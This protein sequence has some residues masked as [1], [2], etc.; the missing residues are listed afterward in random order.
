LSLPRIQHPLFSVE[1]PSSKK[2]IKFRPFTARE[3]K[4]LLIAKQSEDESDIMGAIKQVVRNCVVSEGFDVDKLTIFDLEYLFLQIRIKSVSDIVPV[5]YIDHSDE[6]T[7]KF[8]IDLKQVKV[9]WPIE[10]P[11]SISLGNNMSMTMKWPSADLYSDSQ[12]LSIEGPDALEHL[13]AKCI[14][15]IY[16][17]DQTY[18][19]AMYSTKDL[20]D[21]IQ[22]IDSN[23]YNEIKEFFENMP[24]LQ[25][26][27]TYKNT[28]DEDRRIELSALTDFFQFQ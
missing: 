19:P 16:A 13:I 5:S 14:N 21:F 1:I 12:L 2:A 24:R 8:D 20:I 26:I 9:I 6:Q 7:Y 18:D 10:K 11:P 4:V 22:D 28:K 15:K 17:G 23:S 3:E 27:I 25:Y